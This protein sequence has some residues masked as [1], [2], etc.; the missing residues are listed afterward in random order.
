MGFSKTEGKRDSNSK[1]V[2]GVGKRKKGVV[3]K[4]QEKRRHN[5]KQ[6]LLVVI[7]NSCIF[8]LFIQ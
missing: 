8:N 3:Y 5:K 7:N 1:N 2:K 6:C 4:Q